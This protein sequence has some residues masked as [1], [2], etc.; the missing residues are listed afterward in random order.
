MKLNHEVCPFD[1]S[2]IQKLRERLRKKLLKKCRG[3]KIWEIGKNCY[4]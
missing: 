1:H 2:W 3:R 4:I